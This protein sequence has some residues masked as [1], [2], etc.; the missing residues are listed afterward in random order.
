[1]P[2]GWARKAN[3]L[4]SMPPRPSSPPSDSRLL[5]R[6]LEFGDDIGRATAERVIQISGGHAVLTP[7]A[8]LLHD[9]NYLAITD[10]G[11]EATELAH[12]AETLMEGEGFSAFEVYPLDP[13]DAERLAPGFES[14]GWKLDLGVYMVHRGP[15]DRP[16]DLPVEEVTG[17]ELGGFFRELMKATW[18]ADY[19]GDPDDV[20]DQF[21][22]R[23]R[24]Y[25]QFGGDRWFVA[26]DQGERAACCYLLQRDGLGQV[27]TVATRAASRNKGLAR[28]VILAAVEASKRDGDELTFIGAEQDDWPKDLYRRL[29]FEPVGIEHAFVTGAPEK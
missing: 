22:A 1:M 28:A 5:R 6:L 21:V 7:S 17:E 23:E 26:S 9:S 4:E 20:T 10:S 25:A 11:R 14:L 29:G 18:S 2:E 16:S 24:A 19:A 27:E 12:M 13:V 8:D 15:P 3:R